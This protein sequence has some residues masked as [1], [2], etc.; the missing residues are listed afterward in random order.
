MESAADWP[1][2]ITRVPRKP[3]VAQFCAAKWPN[4]T[5]PLTHDLGVL[6]SFAEARESTFRK[7][8]LPE[9]SQRKGL[10]RQV[11]VSAPLHRPTDDAAGKQIDRDRQIQKPLAGADIGD[12]SDPEL[13][14]GTRY[15]AVD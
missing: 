11:G 9:S 7:P 12:V 8:S 3:K 5:P 15:P 6:D 1:P 2:P 13:I 14:R 10:Q 4:F